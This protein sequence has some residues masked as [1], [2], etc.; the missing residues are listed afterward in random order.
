MPASFLTLCSG[1]LDA[2]H[3]QLKQFEAVQHWLASSGP[4]YGLHPVLAE[5]DDIGLEMLEGVL[6]VELKVRKQHI[7]LPSFAYM[8][9]AWFAQEKPTDG[10]IPISPPPTLDLPRLTIKLSSSPGLQKTV[11]NFLA[12]ASQPALFKSKRSPHGELSYRS[13]QGKKVFR[14]EKGFISQMGDVTRGDGSGGESI[15]VSFFLFFSGCP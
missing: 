5:L 7:S 2:Y 11:K 15:C 1:D 6:P 10:S 3:A 12:F 8:M 4:S 13:E 9:C 14:I